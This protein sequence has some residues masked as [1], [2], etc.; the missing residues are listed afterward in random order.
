MPNKINT[1]TMPG[2][3]MSPESIE[4]AARSISAVGS[5]VSTQGGT[6][7]TSWQK[8]SASYHAPEDTVLFHAM[9]PVKAAAESFGTEVG[10]AVTALNTF[11]EEVRTIKAAVA[12]IRADAKTFIDSVAGGVEQ[13]TPQI[14]GET[15]TVTVDWDKDQASVDANNAL[16]RRT[17]DQQEAL[18]AAERRCANA[19]Y[20]VIGHAHVEAEV[21]AR[22]GALA[23]LEDGQRAG[24]TGDGRGVITGRR[25]RQ[26]QG[27]IVRRLRSCA[28]KWQGND[29]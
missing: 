2:D 20:D 13:Q 17:N 23:P 12:T 21:H 18:W 6:V 26:L 29:Q 10:T 14:H 4:A 16:I 11:A 19:I 22:T 7:L 1:A 9:D 3:N 27:G 25:R 8:I 24:T 5:K 15:T 28:G